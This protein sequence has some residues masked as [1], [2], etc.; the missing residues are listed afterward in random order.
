MNLLIGCDPEVF[1]FDPVAQ[2]FRSA[3]GR[4]PGNKAE[5][6]PVPQGA[7]QIDGTALEFNTDPASTADE[8]ISNIAAVRAKMREFVGDGFDIVSVPVAEYTD[9][10][11]ETIPKAALEL[12]CNPDFNA[13]T[14]DINPA[15]D[16]AVKF[17][18]GS[19]HVHIGW[20]SGFQVDG[21]S[22]FMDCCKITKQL[23][24]YVGLATLLW[25]KDDRRRSLYGKAGAMRPKP[26]GVEYRVPS[27]AWLER[28]ETQRFVYEATVK[29]V[30]DLASG[31][32]C[33]D[34]WGDLARQLIDTN[35]GDWRDKYDFETG[36]DYSKVA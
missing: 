8:F 18:T 7:V 35:Q 17:R 6:Y 15:P 24:Y 2:E 9:D 23:D 19:G 29:A 16:V 1:L 26:Y 21:Y 28:E 34:R 27:N 20:G 12:G 3:H 32:V 36:L 11:Y 14:A 33:E 30:N 13:W 31:H 10:Y 22:H 25:D 4:L 5:P